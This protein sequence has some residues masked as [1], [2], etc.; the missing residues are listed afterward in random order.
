MK[1]HRIPP[2]WGA[3]LFILFAI[4]VATWFVAK[5]IKTNLLMYDFSI[6]HVIVFVGI[7]FSAGRGYTVMDSGLKVDILGIPLFT[8]KWSRIWQIN[9]I[10]RKRLGQQE[11]LIVLTLYGCPAYSVGADIDNYLSRHP[12]KA[13]SIPVYGEDASKHIDAIKEHFQVKEINL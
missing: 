1:K 7:A 5:D 6:F 9:I 3:F 2:N 12:F 4:V 13:I 10:K 11:T 8:I